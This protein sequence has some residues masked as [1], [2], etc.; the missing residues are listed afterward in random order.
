MRGWKSKHGKRLL[1][2]T[3]IARLRRGII[4]SG[5][6]APSRPFFMCIVKYMISSLLHL[7]GNQYT[8][9][10]GKKS[11]GVLCVDRSANMENAFFASL[12]AALLVT[13]RG[14][15]IASLIGNHKLLE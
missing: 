8:R 10:I 11:R 7:V 13:Q 6:Y 9:H 12:G 4:M 14:A 1:C 3:E 15:K 2:Y 5:S